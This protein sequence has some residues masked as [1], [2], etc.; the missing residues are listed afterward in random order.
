M[1]LRGWPYLLSQQSLYWSLLPWTQT[2]EGQTARLSFLVWIFLLCEASEVWHLTH[3]LD[4]TS[5]PCRWLSD[6]SEPIGRCLNSHQCW[7]SARQHTSIWEYEHLF[8][9]IELLIVYFVLLCQIFFSFS[10][11]FMYAFVFCVV[12]CKCMCVCACTQTHKH[13]H[14]G[15]PEIKI[16]CLS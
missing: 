2:K 9:Y 14:F 13:T 15:R 5:F 1:A 12:S 7:K 11:C 6:G 8:T 10:D 4:P 3:S 16:R